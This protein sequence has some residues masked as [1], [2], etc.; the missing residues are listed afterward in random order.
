M[1]WLLEDPETLSFEQ[2]SPRLSLLSEARRNR[3]LS[4]KPEGPRVQSVLSELLLRRALR[5][6]YGLTEFPK[7]ETGEKGKPFFPDHPEIHFNLSHCKYAVACALDRAPLGVDAEALGRLLR[8]G[9]Q[10]VSETEDPKTSPA[11]RGGEPPP[12][13][14]EGSPRRQSPSGRGNQLPSPSSEPLLLRVLSEAER[15][16]VLAGES[17]A[18]QDRRFTAVWTCKEA[19][20]KAQGVGI[21]YDLK[22]TCF[23]PMQES[24]RQGDFTFFHRS[25]DAYELTLCSRELL[26]WECV[27]AEEIRYELSL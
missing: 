6:E 8:P 12:R 15:A 26:P 13:A 3:V 27:S 10:P 9:A 4:M 17:P 20:G 1:L 23:L 21:L 11:R 22:S 18:E 14:V 2:L 19:L 25:R 24:W 7:I 16:W 5:E